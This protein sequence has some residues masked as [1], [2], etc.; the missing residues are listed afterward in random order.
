[1]AVAYVDLQA[2]KFGFINEAAPTTHT[3]IVSGSSYPVGGYVNNGNRTAFLIGF[4]TFPTALKRN[5]LYGGQVT[6][7]ASKLERNGSTVSTNWYSSVG[8]AVVDDF[9]ASTITWANYPAYTD[10]YSTYYD[11]LGFG[12][13]TPEWPL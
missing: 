13:T 2:V 3:T 9:D 12:K 10:G 8:M 1:M 7:Y 5:K 6:A 4:D 11:F